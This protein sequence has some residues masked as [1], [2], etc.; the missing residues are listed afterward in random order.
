MQDAR[1]WTLVPEWRWAIGSPAALSR[2]WNAYHVEVVATT[3]TVAGVKVHTVGH[4]E[5]AYVIDAKGYERALFL[6]PYSADGVVKT[7]R[8]LTP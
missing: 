8:T 6:W 5:A 1:K 3:K 2:V 7:L 4:T